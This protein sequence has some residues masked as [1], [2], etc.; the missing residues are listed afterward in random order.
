[1]SNLIN[2]FAIRKQMNDNKPICKANQPI[3]KKG[4]K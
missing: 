2:T 1:M 4:N 3:G